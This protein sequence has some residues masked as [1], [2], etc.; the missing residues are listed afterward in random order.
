MWVI[1]D[2][3]P[4]ASACQ[5]LGL[6]KKGMW[7]HR[8]SLVVLLQDPVFWQWWHQMLQKEWTKRGKYWMTIPCHPVPESIRQRVRNTKRTRLCPLL[9][10]LIIAEGCFWIQLYFRPSNIPWQWVPH[11]DCIVWR[12]PSLCLFLNLLSTNLIGVTPGS[13]DM[14]MQLCSSRLPQYG[15]WPLFETFQIRLLFHVSGILSL[16]VASVR[17][18]RGRYKKPWSEVT[19]LPAQSRSFLIPNCQWMVYGLQQEV[20]NPVE[21][22][23]WCSY[24]YK[25]F[26]FNLPSSSLN[27]FLW[28][29]EIPFYTT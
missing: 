24:P 12:K 19:K 27:V 8:I 9:S 28:C 7:P 11:V 4:S 25:C 2:S 23:C 13:K 14:E 29:K 16:T 17:C 26:F 20:F 1:P 10:G 3:L 18:V 15:L 22:N 21:Y 5:C 6:K